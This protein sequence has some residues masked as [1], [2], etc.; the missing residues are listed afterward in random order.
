[1]KKILL[2]A[3]LLTSI[4]CQAQV[5]TTE[6]LVEIEYKDTVD[7]NT[8]YKTCK[9][10]LKNS[11]LGQ[12]AEKVVFYFLKISVKNKDVALKVARALNK[13]GLLSGTYVQQLSA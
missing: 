11:Q 12:T 3:V 1:M 7:Y 9:D 8:L 4:T 2:P 6:K 13:K 10:I 5:Q